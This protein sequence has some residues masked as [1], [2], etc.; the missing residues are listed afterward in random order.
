MTDSA[1]ELMPVVIL[2]G[3]Y[4]TR[5][6]PLTEHVPKALIDVA[7]QPFLWHQLQLLKSHGVRRVVLAVGFLAERIQTHFG[8]GSE[9]GISIEYS[10]DGPRPL[11]TAGAIRK[12]LPLL[13]PR[14]FVLYGD[15]YLMCDYRAVETAFG[16]SHLSGM[17]TIYRNDGSFDTSNVEYDGMRILRYDKANQ[18]PS[19]RYIDYGLGA[20]QRAVFESIPAE[21]KYDLVD[22]YQN[23]LAAGQLAALEVHERFYEI[24]SPEGL[25]ETREFLSNPLP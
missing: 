23:L 19:M 11:G 21:E 2:A 4:A 12:A 14:F 8:D 10:F 3:G 6:R 16:R 7:G 18:T 17:M 5:L 15:S 25:R 1:V 24:G 9:L 20:F 13:P 22:V